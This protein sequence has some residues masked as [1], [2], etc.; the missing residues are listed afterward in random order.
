MMYQAAICGMRFCVSPGARLEIYDD[1]VGLG[2]FRCRADILGTNDIYYSQDSP[3]HNV[4]WQP[5][6]EPVCSVSKPLS[7]QRTSSAVD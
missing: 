2:V 7:G 1:A 5:T 4:V 3:I 6:C